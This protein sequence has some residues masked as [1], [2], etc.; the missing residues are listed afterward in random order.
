MARQLPSCLHKL[1]TT[2][3][4]T[5]L[6]CLTATGHLVPMGTNCSATLQHSRNLCCLHSRRPRFTRAQAVVLCSR[7]DRL[8]CWHSNSLAVLDTVLLG[9]R[10]GLECIMSKLQHNAR[11]QGLPSSDLRPFWSPP[12]Q[13]IARMQRSNIFGIRLLHQFCVRSSLLGGSEVVGPGQHIRC[14]STSTGREQDSGPAFDKIL[15][16]NRGE[17]ACRIIRTAR[18][19]GIKTVAGVQ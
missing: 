1:E 14:W 18:R 17:I 19:L 5:T 13:M 2:A 9:M 10:Y 12:N 6:L 8:C 11:E 3:W 15:I 16:A 7:T 4:Q